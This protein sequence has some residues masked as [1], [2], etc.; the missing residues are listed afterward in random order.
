MVTFTGPTNY[1]CKYGDLYDVYNVITDI[2]VIASATKIYVT[3]QGDLNTIF[4]SI[5]TPG[6]IA[7]PYDTGFYVGLTDLNG[8]FAGKT[9]FTIINGSNTQYT[10]TLDS[11]NYYMITFTLIVDYTGIVSDNTS[12][13]TFG[14]TYNVNLYLVGGG[15]SGSSYPD[16]NGGGGGGGYVIPFAG[17]SP[18][19]LNTS[20]TL[21]YNIQI[22]NG[23]LINTSGSNSSS[24]ISSDNSFSQI[25]E[26]GMSPAGQSNP[27]GGTGQGSTNGTNTGYGGNGGQNG[28]AGTTLT[29]GSNPPYTYGNGGGGTNSSN[30]YVSGIGYGGYSDGQSPAYGGTVILYFENKP[31]YN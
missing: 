7:F 16:N 10:A 26:A 11:N 24:F 13:I 29:I 28:Y 5:T 12:I 20:N 1:I 18:P 3:G 9:P 27:T 30:G 14:Y 6:S 2:S 25:A 23:Q 21:S 4:E 8:I 17:A 19:N 31:I 22:G 15:G